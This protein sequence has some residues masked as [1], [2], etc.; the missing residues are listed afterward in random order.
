MARRAFFRRIAAA[1]LLAAAGCSST[2]FVSTWSAPDAE[3]LRL[4]GSKVAA[5]FMTRNTVARRTGEEAMA[6]E[7]TARGAQGVPS[8]TVLSDDAIRNEEQA[9]ATFEKLGFQGTVAMRVVGKETQYTYTPSYWSSYPYYGRF[10]GGYWGWGWGTVY[11]P[12]Y[13]TADKVVSVET[14]V[15]SLRQDKLVWAGVSQTVDPTELNSFVSELAKAVT[16]KM[17]DAGLL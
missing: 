11:Q 17:K 15:Y 10:W 1:V 9:R 7:I 13:L 8:Y 14:L 4:E 3:R 5:V 2:S 6:R 16:G 12:G